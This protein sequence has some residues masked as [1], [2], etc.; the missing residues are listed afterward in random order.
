MR[1]AGRTTVVVPQYAPPTNVIGSTGGGAHSAAGSHA[2]LVTRGASFAA[3]APLRARVAVRADVRA[4]LRADL[5]VA[6]LG[7][8]VAVVAGRGAGANLHARTASRGNSRTRRS[9]GHS[10]GSPPFEAPRRAMQTSSPKV[11]SLASS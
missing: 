7:R 2:A 11:G 1:S 10:D 9:S 5:E 4:A 3:H 8:L 6:I